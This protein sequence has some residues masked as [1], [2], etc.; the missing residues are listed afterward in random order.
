[1][2]RPL[3]STV[4]LLLSAV[5]GAS[6]FKMTADYRETLVEQHHAFLNALAQRES[7]VSLLGERAGCEASL[8][9]IVQRDRHW[10]LNRSLRDSVLSHPVSLDFAELLEDDRFA[11]REL[12]LTDGYGA[13]LAA[14][15]ATSDYWQGD[16][17]KFIRPVS[18]EAMVV[19]NASWDESSGVYSFF[20]SL[21]LFE[22]GRLLGVLIAGID[23]SLEYYLSMPLEALTHLSLTEEPVP[24]LPQ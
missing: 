9:T 2:H 15:P 3:V 19:S 22:D 8:H 23:V 5:A 13:L 4:F 1:M 11:I 24:D 21:P 20:I 16:E 18:T 6:P 10:P 7:L 12:M 17:D 14:S